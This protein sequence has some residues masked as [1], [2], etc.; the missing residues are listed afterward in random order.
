[1]CAT[2]LITAETW[3]CDSQ[4]CQ[5]AKTVE[6]AHSSVVQLNNTDYRL[7]LQRTHTHPAV[8]SE[9]H[10]SL[11]SRDELGSGHLL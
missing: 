5:S 9:E 7:K 8:E 10:K 4:N 11:N 3:S 1:M 2:W 6:L